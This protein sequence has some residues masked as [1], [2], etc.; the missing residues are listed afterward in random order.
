[1]RI[2][3]VIIFFF[4]GSALFGQGYNRK[5]KDAFPQTP[6][7]E[8]TG[9]YFGLG[10]NYPLN[11]AT[12][13]EEEGTKIGDTTFA[14]NSNPSGQLGT[15]AE[16]GRYHMI[17]NLY[18]FRYWNYGLN[19]RWIHGKERFENQGITPTGNGPVELGENSFSDHFLNAHIE[20]SGV[21]KLSDKTFLQHTIGVQAGYAI[22]SKRSY[23]TNLPGLEQ[24]TQNRL[25]SY[26]YYRL[27]WGARVSKKLIMIPSIEVPLLNAYTFN[28]GRYDMPYF[29]SHYWP[30]TFSVRFLLCRPY[31]LK[32]CPPVDALG[33]PD[34]FDKDEPG[35]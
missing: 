14:T 22:L 25:H 11:V 10:A 32:S 4:V 6:R 21:N 15:F 13:K 33:L 23:S 31:R 8:K 24:K 20:I 29:N 5:K 7:F 35:K 17:E 30:I 34:G 12:I 18:F 3:I 16:F 26:V 28:S 1:V 9:W 2:A 19:Y 27:G